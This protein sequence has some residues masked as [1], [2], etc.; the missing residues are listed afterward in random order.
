M[1]SYGMSMPEK[2]G[3]IL[4]RKCKTY[5]E[6]RTGKQKCPWCNE[7][8]PVSKPAPKPVVER[9]DDGG[10]SVIT[11]NQPQ[12]QP[13]PKPKPTTEKGST[14]DNPVPLWTR[15]DIIRAMEFKYGEDFFINGESIIKTND[16]REVKLIQI[17][18]DTGEYKNLYFGYS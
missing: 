6:E 7:I 15:M 13:K 12:S 18:L 1:R 8:K 16:G 14:A 5:Y 4:C 3:K 2:S 17:K 9:V 11:L 10:I